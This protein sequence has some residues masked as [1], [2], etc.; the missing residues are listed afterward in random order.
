MTFSACMAH[1]LSHVEETASHESESTGL[2]R[3]HLLLS[4]EINRLA[5]LGTNDLTEEAEMVT[6]V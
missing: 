3:S 1:L 5:T 2:E 6:S 4:F